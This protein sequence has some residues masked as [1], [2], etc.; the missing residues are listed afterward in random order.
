MDQNCKFGSRRVA[1]VSSDY[2][3]IFAV[4]KI[5]NSRGINDFTLSFT[6]N[7]RFCL[8]SEYIIHE[9]RLDLIIFE[10]IA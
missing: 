6:L 7:N 1:D 8:Q 5:Q 9:S 2:N 4:I 3:C 10:Q